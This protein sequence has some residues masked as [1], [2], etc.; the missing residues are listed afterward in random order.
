MMVQR[1]CSKQK[2]GHVKA[3]CSRRVRR[4]AIILSSLNACPPSMRNSMIQKAPPDLIDA[5]CECA[6]NILRGNVK[7]SKSQKEGLQKHKHKLRKLAAKSVPR[8][9]KKTLLNQKGGFMSVLFPLISTLASTLFKP[10]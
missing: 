8:E 3:K 1:K 2:D 4:N 7:L 6:L 10:A 9:Q 5:I